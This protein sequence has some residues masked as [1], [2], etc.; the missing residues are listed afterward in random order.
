M[1]KIAGLIIYL[2]LLFNGLLYL[3]IDLDSKNLAFYKALRQKS[4]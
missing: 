3:E 2:I 4:F 1:T